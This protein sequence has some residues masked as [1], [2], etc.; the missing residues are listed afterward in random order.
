MSSPKTKESN[1]LKVVVRRKEKVKLEKKIRPYIL[2]FLGVVAIALAILLSYIGYTTRE[3][4]TPDQ[5][6]QADNIINMIK[7]KA[8][9]TN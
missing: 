8:N 7:E 9:A 2:P 5:V 3:T 6:E 1:K 4:D